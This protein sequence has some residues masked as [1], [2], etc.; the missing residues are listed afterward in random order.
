M[1]LAALPL[2]VEAA[3]CDRCCLHAKKGLG[4]GNPM[5]RL[6]LV[7]QNPGKEVR[8]NTARVPFEIQHWETNKATKSSQV[9]RDMMMGVGLGWDDFYVTNVMKCEGIVLPAYIG[10]CGDWLERELLAL[11]ELQLIVVMGEI[12]ARR[13]VAPSVGR[14]SWYV[15]RRQ[16]GKQWPVTRVTHPAAP[17]YPDGI[18]M[19]A[20]QQQ[21]LFVA[22]VY[23]MLTERCM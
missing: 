16:P 8:Q 9:L 1:L 14:L 15:S 10:N 6:L 4:I 2:N 5:A 22:S 19:T 13:L 7:A 20:Y 12:A 11:S 21:W 23:R 17:L 18:S 3:Q